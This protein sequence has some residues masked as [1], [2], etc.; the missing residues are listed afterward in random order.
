MDA[1]GARALRRRI[2]QQAHWR[3]AAAVRD[4]RQPGVDPDLA[5]LRELHR[6]ERIYEDEV[7][8]FVKRLIGGA[9]ARIEVGGRRAL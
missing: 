5:T 6:G 2:V 9:W 8:P 7:G 3:Q 4:G 1:A